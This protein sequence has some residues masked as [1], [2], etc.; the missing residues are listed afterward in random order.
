MDE[1][2][3]KGIAGSQCR[4]RL[5]R[6]YR[7]PGFLVLSGRQHKDRIGSIPGNHRFLWP[8][9]AVFST[10]PV[11]EHLCCGLLTGMPRHLTE[12]VTA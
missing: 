8:S 2:T 7:N 1:R 5:H 6:L 10:H 12:L 3:V 11:Q 9:A 4:D